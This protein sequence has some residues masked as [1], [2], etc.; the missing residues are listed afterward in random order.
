MSLGTT[1]W[2]SDGLAKETKLGRKHSRETRQA[3]T[4]H[5]CRLPLSHSF[6]VSANPSSKLLL[7]RQ[8]IVTRCPTVSGELSVLGS[9]SMVWTFVITELV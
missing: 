6:S 4:D 2:V 9:S 8:L 7:A 3:N 1:T 5:A